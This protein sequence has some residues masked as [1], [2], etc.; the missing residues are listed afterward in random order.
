M[1]TYIIDANVVLKWILRENEA[2]VI[3]SQTIYRLMM[4]DKIKLAAPAS[5][6][7]EV[8]NVMFWKKLFRPSDILKFVARI[9]NSK[10]TFVSL[11]DFTWRELLKTMDKYQSSVYDAYYLCLA[12]KLDCKLITWD[13]ELLKIKSMA[14]AADE[15]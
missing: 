14:I 2:G 8:I 9:E 12:R 6:I 3:E 1:T 11:S 4:E 7:S 5:L 15:I 13:Q 10:L